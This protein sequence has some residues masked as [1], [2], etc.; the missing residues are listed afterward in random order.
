MAA[1]CSLQSAVRPAGEAG[2]GDGG[3]VKMLRVGGTARK[4]LLRSQVRAT[5]TGSSLLGPDEPR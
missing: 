3:G 1:V 4:L 5:K 2:G